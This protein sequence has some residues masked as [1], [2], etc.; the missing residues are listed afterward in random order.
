[1]RKILTILIFSLIINICNATDYAI[2]IS[3]GKATTDDTFNNSEFWYS[4]YLAYEDLVIKEG[5][6]PENVFVFY[7]DGTDF[8]ATT[9]DRYQLSLHDWSS[10]TDY[11]NSY[12]TMVTQFT[13]LGNTIT[14]SDNVLI[15]WVVGHGS[16]S[17]TDNYYA[18]IS[19]QGTYISESNL[20]SLI[21]LISDYNKM[22]IL[23][24]T[25]YS[26]C[27]V[28]GSNTLNNDNTVIITA[29]DWD[30]YSYAYEPYSDIN[31]E[32]HP[33]FNYLIT[34][35]LYGEGPYETSFSADE[36]NDNIPSMEE[37]YDAT[38]SCSFMR[39]D[40]QLGDQCS[41]ADRTYIDEDLEI[42]ASITSTV[43]YAA[44]TIAVSNTSISNSADVH[45]VAQESVL[46]STGFYA[47][48]ATGSTHAY[49]AD[50]TCSS[51]LKFNE[52][53]ETNSSN[54][55]SDI[56][57]EI[58]EL[59]LDDFCNNITLYPNPATGSFSIAGVEKGD[60][61]EVFD[62]SGK[63]IV[64]KTVKDSSAELDLSGSPQGI[65]MVS[66]TSERGVSTKKLIIQ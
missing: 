26:G 64:N 51:T 54:S 15:R 61:I 59:S 13:T 40:A 44:R 10:I 37:L 20:I 23:W 65:Y 58:H 39:S 43:S 50:E 1:M 7:G 4:L 27:L 46:F 49:I 33:E 62:Y 9:K 45:F 21:S 48:S 63:L 57:Y 25:C 60:I 52:L 55:E 30:E 35:C 18:S 38:Q 66:I 36:N 24:M 22:K 32:P 34:S 28:K 14:S 47:S 31:D 3:A 17:T 53:E 41:I 42:E 2:L 8:T 29:S 11:D 5:Y 56:T 16:A 19:N 6:L 12:S